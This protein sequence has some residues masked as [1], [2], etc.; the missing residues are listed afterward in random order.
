[1]VSAP[2]CDVSTDTEWIDELL[3]PP[4]AQQ[5]DP[6]IRL[7]ESVKF[8]LILTFGAGGQDVIHPVSD[9]DAY[10]QHFKQ[11]AT[12]INEL[13]PAYR[14]AAEECPA[15]TTRLS[16]H[17]KQQVFADRLYREHGVPIFALR[18][19]CCGMPDD[20][21][22]ATVWRTNIHKVLNFLHLLDTGVQGFVQDD[23]GN[24]IRDASVSIDASAFS[25]VSTNMAHFKKILSPG[26]YTIVVRANGF[27]D[28]KKEFSV[29]KGI[30]LSLNKIVLTASGEH[31]RLASGPTAQVTGIYLNIHLYVVLCLFTHKIIKYLY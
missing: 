26:A 19:G 10:T 13:P 5:S 21:H 22:V 30:L 23:K 27:A 2:I 31:V 6:L 8:D 7:I 18:L 17:H 16:M 11:S 29:D 1:M 9:S 4:N 14:S 3:A 15:T 28:Y 12:T 25:N 20:K 24:P